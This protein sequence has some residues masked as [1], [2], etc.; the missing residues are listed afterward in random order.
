MDNTPSQLC[1]FCM[2]IIVRY[3]FSPPCFCTDGQMKDK[4]HNPE[5]EKEF[6]KQIKRHDGSGDTDRDG[7]DRRLSSR[8]DHLKNGRCKGE[9]HKDDKYRDRYRDDLDRDHRYR[10]DKHKDERSRDSTMDRSDKSSESCHKKAKLQSS[11]HDGSPYVDD[12]GNRNEDDKGRKRSS[13]DFE[14][15]GDLNTR[16]NKQHLTDGVKSALSGNK[17]DSDVADHCTPSYSLLKSSPSS[18]SHAVKD[19][20]RY[21]PHPPLLST[22]SCIFLSY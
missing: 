22:V 21:L 14:D 1:T 8:D 2:E 17:L 3:I 5:L 20:Y 9:R 19:H 11:D 12:R 15:R 7:E 18:G 13:Y 4:L 10:D 6:V 16:S